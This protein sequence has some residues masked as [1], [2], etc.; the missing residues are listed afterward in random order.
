MP[1]YTPPVRDVRFVLDHVVGLS[2]HSNL[3]GFQNATP[4]VV[5]AVLDEGGKFV[6]EV[7][8]PL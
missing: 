8:F 7:L 2:A 1:K 5:D 6:A 3:A 4:D